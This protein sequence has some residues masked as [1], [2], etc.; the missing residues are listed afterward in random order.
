MIPGPA[1]SRFA[2]TIGALGLV[3]IFGPGCGD[4]KGT[5]PPPPPP[6]PP[7]PERIELLV[8]GFP[9]IVQPN[10]NLAT[11]QGVSLGRRLFYDP[12]LSL[13]NSQ[14]CGSCHAPAFAFS[15]HGRRFSLGAEGQVGNRNSPA[16][17]NLAWSRN[18][19]WNGRA[20]HLEAQAF[21]PVENPIEMMEQWSHVVTKLAEDPAYPALFRAAFG[22]EEVTADRTVKAIAQFERTLLS[23]DSKYDRILKGEESF[24]PGEERGYNMFFTEKADCFHCHVDYLFTDYGFHDIGL[25]N[26]PE[27]GRAEVTNRPEDIGRHKVPTLRNVVFS[28]PYM[29]DG[30]FPTLR[31]VIEHYNR[32]GAG[33]P[34]QSPFV[35]FG[36]GLNLTEQ[37]K[38]DLLDFIL[39]LTDSSFVSNPAFQDPF[40][41]GLTGR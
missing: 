25:D 27:L 33:T 29:H 14:S 26:P 30:R 32:G 12:R 11:R 34:N 3:L 16:L 40:V 9:A 38:Q 5:E 6:P 20:E 24:T 35:H 18:V 13:N 15:D 7:D 37:D 36:R 2:A 22:D 31:D 21:Q 1:G 4:G 19:F 39:T 28:A 23:Y 17:V 41:G 8:P 10:D